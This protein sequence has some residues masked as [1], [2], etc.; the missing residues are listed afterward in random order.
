M[1]ENA[2]LL[3]NLSC[4][5]QGSNAA[6]A[7]Q[8]LGVWLYRDGIAVHN[9]QAIQSENDGHL[10]LFRKKLAESQV[11][12]R[13]FSRCECHQCWAFIL[14]RGLTVDITQPN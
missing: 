4:L 9:L 1:S 11:I 12:I 10:T 14:E 6:F 2:K 3:A 8:I 7:K 13:E 5:M